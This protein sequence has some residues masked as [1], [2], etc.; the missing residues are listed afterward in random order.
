MTETQQR[1]LTLSN[2]KRMPVRLDEPTWTAIEYLAECSGQKWQGWCNDTLSELCP[3]ENITAGLREA[4]MDGILAATVFP[5]RAVQCS[6]AVPTWQNL[7]EC[8]DRDFDYA[9]E[10]ASKHGEIQGHQDFG[11]FTLYSGLSE[12]GN[13]T[14]YVRNNMREGA[15]VIINT[16]FKIDE[17]SNAFAERMGS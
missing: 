6:S 12:W 7:G 10:Q 13:V 17:W 11:G 14:Y 16:P 5:E 15:S 8:D 2:G 4:A 1:M 9:L 3:G